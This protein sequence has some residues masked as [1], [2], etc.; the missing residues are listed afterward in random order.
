[1]K[2]TTP[3][4]SHC[5]NVLV[6]IA[7]AEKQ[8]GTMMGFQPIREHHSFLKC[9]LDHISISSETVQYGCLHIRPN[10]PYHLGTEGG[11]NKFHHW[12]SVYH[13]TNL[14]EKPAHLC[15]LASVSVAMVTGFWRDFNNTTKRPSLANCLWINED[16]FKTVWQQKFI[17]ENL[18]L[19]MLVNTGEIVNQNNVWILEMAIICPWFLATSMAQ[20]KMSAPFLF[21]F[22]FVLEKNNRR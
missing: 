3:T 8:Q 18:L 2:W 10:Y 9:H 11:C 13:G 14:C 19:L 1:M 5:Q 7:L 12:S 22:F 17:S 20:K 21:F 15:C 4:A 6:F 16:L